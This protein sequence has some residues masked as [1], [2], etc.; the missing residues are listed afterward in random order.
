MCAKVWMFCFSF[1]FVFSFNSI[2]LLPLLLSPPTVHYTNWWW[3]LYANGVAADAHLMTIKMTMPASDFNSAWLRCVIVIVAT[4]FPISYHLKSAAVKP[5]SSSG[6][7]TQFLH[8]S[9]SG[10]WWLFIL[11]DLLCTICVQA[12]YNVYY[13]YVNF[14]GHA[15]WTGCNEPS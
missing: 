8:L 14:T 3:W 1:H 5:V 13:T 6:H 10:W 15:F 7:V 9:S 12:I 11:S 4:P 2:C